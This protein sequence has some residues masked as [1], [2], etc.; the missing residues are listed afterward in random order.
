MVSGGANEEGAVGI[1]LL[2]FGQ[3]E[4]ECVGWVVFQGAVGSSSQSCIHVPRSGGLVVTIEEAI[5]KPPCSCGSVG[6]ESVP[7]AKS[8][9][10]VVPRLHSQEK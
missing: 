4:V 3:W 8:P 5:N 10:H 2:G 7:A 9:D 6:A 1:D